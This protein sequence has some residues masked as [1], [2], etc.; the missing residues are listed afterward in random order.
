MQND[1]FLTLGLGYEACPIKRG[2]L[3]LYIVLLHCIYIS[4]DA[5][6]FSSF[7]FFVKIRTVVTHLF[8][9]LVQY[10]SARPEREEAFRYCSS[11][12]YSVR[13]KKGPHGW[14]VLGSHSME[15]NYKPT[16]YQVTPM[17]AGAVKAVRGLKKERRERKEKKKL[18]Q[19]GVPR[20]LAFTTETPPTMRS[21]R[22]ES[23]ASRPNHTWPGK[24]T[25]LFSLRSRAP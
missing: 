10:K 6:F 2:Q 24:S 14:N 21:N 20:L 23:T 8:L 15:A 22:D 5:G 17:Q 16:L 25:S 7:F 1:A 4:H 11:V 12:A 13:G 19:A 3:F 18:A 9:A